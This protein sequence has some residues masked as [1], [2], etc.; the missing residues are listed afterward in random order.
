MTPF[1]DSPDDVA[2]WADNDVNSSD[3][4]HFG[5]TSS[6]RIG[7][8]TYKR[9]RK[10]GESTTD[11]SSDGDMLMQQLCEKAKA[12]EVIIYTVAVEADPHGT[13]E[14]AKCAT[15]TFHAFNIKSDE[16]EATFGSIARQITELRL[17][18]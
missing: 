5:Y 13:S 11:G 17:S 6:S 16:M 9:F 1:Y 8:L 10:N 2:H 7:N 3:G 14:L 4:T 18:L 15:S 12:E